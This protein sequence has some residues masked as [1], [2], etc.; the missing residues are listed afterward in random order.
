MKKIKYIK[1][2]RKLKEVDMVISLQDWILKNTN[3]SLVSLGL[4]RHCRTFIKGL[5]EIPLS[6]ELQ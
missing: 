4:N 2:K 1:L 6:E 5:K 3:T